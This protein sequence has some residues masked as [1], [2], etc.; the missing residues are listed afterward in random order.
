MLA[1]V[2]GS[3]GRNQNMNNLIGTHH[4]STRLQFD[5]VGV[6]YNRNYHKT[7]WFIMF[8]I[9]WKK[10]K[11]MMTGGTPISGNLHIQ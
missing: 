8:I 5:S 4:L 2:P 10:Y 6:S 7:G 1:K 11:L 3:K 9:Q